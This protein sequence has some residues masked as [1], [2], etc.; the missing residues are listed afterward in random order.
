MKKIDNLK[1]GNGYLFIKKDNTEF[2]GTFLDKDNKY[3]FIK[4]VKH[5]AKFTS[6]VCLP[7]HMLARVS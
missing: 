1:T 4:N 5:G 2:R 3:I 7:I 6:L